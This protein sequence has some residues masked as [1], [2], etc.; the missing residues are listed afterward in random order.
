MTRRPTVLVAGFS[1]RAL[2]R[3]ALSAGFDVVALDGF[4]DRDLLER[5]PAPSSHVLVQPFHPRAAARLG[6]GVTADAL[7]YTSN[8]ENHPAALGALQRDRALWGNPPAVLRAVRSPERVAGALRDAG[9]PVPR[10]CVDEAEAA[11]R[12]WLVKPRRSGGGRGIRFWTPDAPARRHE[13]VQ[14]WIDGVPAS[15]VFL[16]DGRTAW[17]LALTRQVV[18]DPQFGG[19]GYCYVGSLLASRTAP[20]FDAQESLFASAVAAADALTAAF[21]LVGLNTVDFMARDG[22]AWPVEVNPRHSAS[23]ELLEREL[24]ASLFPWHVDAVNGAAARPRHDALGWTAVPGKAILF[25]RR[26]LTMTGSDALL[27]SADV[28]DVSADG[29]AIPAGAPV[30]TIFARADSGKACIAAL[31]ARGAALLAQ[32]GR[33]SAAA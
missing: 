19:W 5:M 14:E 11:R 4:G 17:P 6:A 12:T 22:V 15:L 18:G 20:L 29:T 2:A 13:Y 23:M 9:L 24:G 16:G 27:A 21:G 33:G 30:C 28:A 31:A 32:L 3:S 7:A 1:A 8:F 10:L 26:R 25:A